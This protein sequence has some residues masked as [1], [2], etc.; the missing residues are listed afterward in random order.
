MERRSQSSGD[1]ESPLIQNDR[2][3]DAE[4]I[5]KIVNVLSFHFTKWYPDIRLKINEESPSEK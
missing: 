5:P 4:N 1:N 3:E 2:R